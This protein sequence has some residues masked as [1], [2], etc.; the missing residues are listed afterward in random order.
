MRR[1]KKFKNIKTST[2][3]YILLYLTVWS[4]ELNKIERFLNIKV[5][6]DLGTESGGDNEVWVGREKTGGE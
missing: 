6:D 4:F 3:F 2:I 1:N 5:F